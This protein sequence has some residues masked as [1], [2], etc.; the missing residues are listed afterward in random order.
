MKFILK[1]GEEVE[2][3]ELQESGLTAEELRKFISATVHEKPEPFL[4]HDIKS[5]PTLK[6]EREWLA[7]TLK[8]IRKKQ[9]IMLVALKNGKLIGNVAA[10]K[11]VGRHRDKVSFGILISHEYRGLGLGKK[12]M[13]EIIKLVKKRLKPKIIY[14]NVVALNKPAFALYK[15]L[16][17]VE[18]ARFPKWMKVRGKYCDYILMRLK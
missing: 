16:G 7:S 3:L 4:H 6:E 8:N 15:K 1:N 2:I 10:G 5:I 13:V 11:D 14:I 12:L 9:K 18:I 17:F